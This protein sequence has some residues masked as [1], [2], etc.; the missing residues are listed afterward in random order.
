[1]MQW[2]L[3]IVVAAAAGAVV[4]VIMMQLWW[5]PSHWRR[6]ERRLQEMEEA[7]LERIDKQ[8][9][10]AVQEGLVDLASVGTLLERSRS[11]ARTGADIVNEGLNALLG[12]RVRR[13]EGN[14][15]QVAATEPVAAAEEKPESRA[16]PEIVGPESAEPAEEEK[17]V[18][19]Q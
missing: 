1:M 19:R 5:L 8:M 4:A 17:P 3:M 15:P 14:G 18:N 10:K 11:L 9:R 7:I 12:A 16:E 2:F 13:Y 6:Q